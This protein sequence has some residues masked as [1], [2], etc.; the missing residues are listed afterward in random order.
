MG[1]QRVGHDSV[2]NTY[3]L[4]L[5]LHSGRRYQKLQEKPFLALSRKLE[6][7]TLNTRRCEGS[8]W[9]LLFSLFSFRAVLLPT[10]V[11]WTLKTQ[12]KTCFSP[13]RGTILPRV[14]KESLYFFLTLCHEEGPSC[15]ELLYNERLTLKEIHL[16]GHINPHVGVQGGDGAW[17][18]WR[19]E[20][21]EGDHLILYVI[22]RKSE[23]FLKEQCKEIEENNTVGKTRDL[24]KKIGDI[25]GTFYT[26]MGT[27]MY[28]NSK[29]LT[30]AEE[31]KN[32]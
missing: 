3:L 2:T 6:Q 29:D 8:P 7:G 17:K 14:W 19:K 31:I 21:R 10:M 9:V 24:F 23:A 18:S 25:K 15:R 32:R 26:K 20:S 1:S 27:I 28:R 22:Q 16:P 13:P 11:A 4:N 12:E 30:K 5:E